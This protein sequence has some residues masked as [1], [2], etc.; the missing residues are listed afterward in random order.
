MTYIIFDQNRIHNSMSR[1][2]SVGRAG[3]C[4]G[5]IS[6]ISR[7]AVQIRLAGFFVGYIQP[8]ENHIIQSYLSIRHLTV[9]LE[10]VSI[11]CIGGFLDTRR[12]ILQGNFISI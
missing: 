10:K 11:E 2:S 7:S 4:R 5:M 1:D 12:E 8:V 9:T 6:G 3:D